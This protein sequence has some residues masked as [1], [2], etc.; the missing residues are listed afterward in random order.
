VSRILS[1]EAA[2]WAERRIQH[3]Q[4]YSRTPCPPPRCTTGSGQTACASA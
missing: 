4:R 2:L 3:E 1:L